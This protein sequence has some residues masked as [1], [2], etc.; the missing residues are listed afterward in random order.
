MVDGPVDTPVVVLSNSIGT[1]TALWDP[2]VAPLAEA[3]R[4]VRYD[5]R[6]HGGSSTPAGEYTMSQLAGDIVTILDDLGIERAHVVGLSVGGQTA[7][8]FALE[9]PDRL[10]RLVVSNTGAKIGTEQS[11][12]DRA[13][14]VRAEGLEAIVDPVTAG[15]LTPDHAAAHPEQLAT[16][17]RWFLANDPEGYAATCHALG[18]TDLNPRLG[19][20]TAKT[21]VISATGD[22]PTPPSLTFE[23]A[24][25]IPGASRVEIPGAHLSVQEAPQ[26]YADAVLAH[27]S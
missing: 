24:D 23:I 7:L 5:S 18:Q 14:K 2:I 11:W 17:K 6:G 16:M 9:H 25:G 19:E 4:V 8:T 22:I 27:L 1:N 26:Q 20:I 13:A 3:H 15:W 12:A 21:L 10:D